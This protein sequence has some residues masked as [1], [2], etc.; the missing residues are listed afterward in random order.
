[1]PKIVLDGMG[2]DQFP[3]PE[4]EAAAEAG[5]SFGEELLITGPESELKPRLE[6]L[7]ARNVRVVHAPDVFKMTDKISGDELRKAQT[8]MA[9]GLALVRQG[10]ADA[11]VSMGN[12]GGVMA[13]ALVQ[14]RRIPGVKRPALTAL[15]PVQKGRCVVLDI[16][17]NAECRPEYLY[18]F[19]VMGAKYAELVLGIERPR[20]GLLSNGEE[21]GKG[22]E[23][24]RE[25]FPLLEQSDLNFTGNVEGKELFFG[26]AD[27][28]VTDGFTGNVLLKSSEAV[29]KLLTDVLREQVYASTR[30]RLGGL[31]M[32]PAFGHVRKMLD[33]AEVGAV[34]LL[35]V[36]GLAFV[37]H[38]RSQAKAIVN[39]IRLARQSVEVGLLESI[40]TAIKSGLKP[41]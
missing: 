31:L 17:A 11:F 1:M 25:T 36:N 20:V 10:E 19:A 5:R 12:T 29:A 40:K 9:V 18:Q 39:A 15:F 28:V 6:A 26:G 2:S 4:V 38:G 30:G 34:P 22:N 32:R 13:N 21:A 14:L 35:G 27:V 24:V 37:G 7:G 3:A 8:S 23:L 41:A 33:P 16:G